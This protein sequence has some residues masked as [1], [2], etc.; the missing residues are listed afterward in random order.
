[1]RCHCFIKVNHFCTIIQTFFEN[2]ISKDFLIP[3]PLCKES[4]CCDIILQEMKHF[5]K[6]V[7]E[8]ALSIH[9]SAQFLR[10]KSFVYR[11][12]SIS[13]PCF[14]FMQFVGTEK[15]FLNFSIIYKSYKCYSLTFIGEICWLINLER[16]AVVFQFIMSNLFSMMWHTINT[17]TSWLF[18]SGT[19]LFYHT[20]SCSILLTLI[21]YAGII[22]FL[23]LGN[24]FCCDWV[25]CFPG[26]P[27]LG[28]H[29]LFWDSSSCLN[30]SATLLIKR[31]WIQWCLWKL[32]PQTMNNGIEDLNYQPSEMYP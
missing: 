13:C 12:L 14:L 30:W 29:C 21:L 27:K 26:L 4:V 11:T 19:F 9:M 23:F 24:K 32:F 20:A 17:S 15:V 5:L 2:F 28:F 10:D 6:P 7:I 25:N 8:R 3:A 16:G 31:L 1:M 22:S 18:E